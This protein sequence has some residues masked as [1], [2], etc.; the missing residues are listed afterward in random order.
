MS[1]WCLQFFKRLTKNLTNF[2]T[3]I[4]K[5]VKSQEAHYNEFDTNYFQIILNIIRRCLYFVDLTT[6]CSLGQKFVK[7]LVVFLENLELSKR[8][9]EINWPLVGV[10]MQN[11]IDPPRSQWGEYN[12]EIHFDFF[13]FH[14]ISHDFTLFYMISYD[15]RSLLKNSTFPK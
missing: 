2:C 12:Y 6:F 1:F 9:S 10:W 15:F 14:F 3:K 5:V 7:F 4:K 8:H 13:L 11:R